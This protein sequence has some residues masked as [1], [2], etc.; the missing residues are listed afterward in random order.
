MLNAFPSEAPETVLDLNVR[1][2]LLATL[3]TRSP[4][5]LA[6][7]ALP[8]HL[9]RRRRSPEGLLLLA[10]T[11]AV[12]LLLAYGDVRALVRK[13]GLTL[14]SVVPSF[15]F[16]FH[17]MTL[18]SVGFG[19]AVMALARRLSRIAS[20][21]MAGAVPAEALAVALTLLV[22]LFNYESYARRHDVTVLRQ[23]AVDFASAMPADAVAWIRGHTANEDVFLASDEVSL[24]VVAPAGRKVVCTNRY[25]SSPYVDW[26]QRERDRIR[27]FAFVREGD[28]E[29]FDRLAASYQVSY[30]VASDGV[31]SFLRRQAGISPRE[32]PPLTRAQMA[33]V[34]GFELVF[35]GETLAVYRRQPSAS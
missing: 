27:L 3:A 18:V 35:A 24:Y 11:L 32:P 5:L 29:G 14:P 1:A 31:P 22:L 34:G 9:W 2:A 8:L 13:G 10:W 30:V 20:T 6:A 17:G 4:F 25:F 33:G 26:A 16:L 19:V 12:V 28:I 23:Q 21:R 7:V 15:H